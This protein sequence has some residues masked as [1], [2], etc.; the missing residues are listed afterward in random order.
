MENTGKKLLKAEKEKAG[1]PELVDQGP[2][3]FSRSEGTSAWQKEPRTSP[4][5]VV[6]GQHYFFFWP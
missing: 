1:T 3:S 5:L 6:A 2:V 4:L